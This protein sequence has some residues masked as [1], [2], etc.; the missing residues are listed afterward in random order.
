[1]GLAGDRRR[2]TAGAAG[3]LIVADASGVVV[4]DADRAEEI[5]IVAED[6]FA[7]EAAMAA[8]LRGGEHP[9]EMMGR[10]YEELLRG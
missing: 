5:V 2:I 7:R 9:S 3:D 10:S 4:L 1:M 8:S 6:I